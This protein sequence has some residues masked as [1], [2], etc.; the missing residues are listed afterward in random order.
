MVS[1]LLDRFFY[2]TSRYSTW[3]GPQQKRYA[4]ETDSDATSDFCL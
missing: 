3:S 1:F 2:T 4:K